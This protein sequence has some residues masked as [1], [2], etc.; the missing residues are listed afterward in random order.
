MLVKH[1]ILRLRQKISPEVVALSVILLLSFGLRLVF[2][3]EPLERDEG[4]YAC[5]AQEI[6]HGGVPYRDVIDVKPPGI[7]YIYSFII[8]IFGGTTEAIRLFTDFYAIFTVLFIFLLTRYIYNS[9]AAIIAALC[10]GVFSN[11]PI[12]Q[13]NSSNT[14][15]FMI[16]PLVCGAYMYLKG[17]DLNNRFFLGLSGFLSGVAILIKPVA[18]PNLLLI[19]FFLACTWGSSGSLRKKLLDLVAFS[20]PPLVLAVLVVLFFV[21]KDAFGDLYY[22]NVTFMKTLGQTQN[23]W[24]RL[25]DN[26]LK[27][28]SEQSLLWLTALPT[29]VMLLIQ[30][31]NRNNLFL[32]AFLLVS[33]VGVSMPGKY[34]VHYFIQIVP[35]LAVLTG[36]GLAALWEKKGAVLFCSI[37]ILLASTVWSFA[38]D[39][40]Y[41]FVY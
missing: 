39:Y 34:F 29:V 8:S 26:G 24:F 21:W 25:W 7:F 16:L 18:L 30:R 36:I 10:Y 9:K 37:P 27:I 20:L 31:R 15:I 23:R 35:A 28:A 22:W 19:M 11:G 4:F 2:Y 1:I 38:K 13:G 14:E 32:V 41:Y 6:L 5:I 33:F 17:Q 40:T 3:H 12:L